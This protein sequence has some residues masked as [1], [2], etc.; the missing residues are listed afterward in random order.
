MIKNEGFLKSLS[1]MMKIMKNKEINDRI[2]IIRRFFKE[3]SDVFGYGIYYFK[4]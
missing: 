2:K 4:K 3:N 1:I